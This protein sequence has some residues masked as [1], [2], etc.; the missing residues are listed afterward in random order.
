MKKIKSESTVNVRIRERITPLIERGI[1]EHYHKTNQALSITDFVTMTLEDAL[2]S[3]SDPEVVPATFAKDIKPITKKKR[4]STRVTLIPVGPYQLEKKEI[5]CMQH[6]KDGISSA[7]LGK[8]INMGSSTVREKLRKVR[9]KLDVE[10]DQQAFDK[11]S[12]YDE[13]ANLVKA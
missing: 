2:S 8:L 3:K 13:F 1:E 5:D 4:A 11:L 6:W 10:T 9:I 12:Q 7:S